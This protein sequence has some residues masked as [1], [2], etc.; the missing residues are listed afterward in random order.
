MPVMNGYEATTEIKKI[1]PEIPIIAQT[2]FA[3]SDEKESCFKY[4][5]DDYISKPVNLN[6]LS[7][8]FS[9]YLTIR[10]RNHISITKEVVV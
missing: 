10:N 8:I 1:N 7:Q 5:C 2:A 3:M 4:G 9:K 6:K